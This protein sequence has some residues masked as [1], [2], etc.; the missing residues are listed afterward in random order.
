MIATPHQLGRYEGKN[1]PA[2]IRL[3]VSRL[4]SALVENQIPLRISPG[5]DVRVDHRLDALL[6]ADKICSLAD[7]GRYLLLELPHETYIELR[8][9]SELFTE[10]GRTLIVSHPERNAVLSRRPDAVAP[11]LAAGAVLQITAGSLLGHFGSTAQSSAWKWLEAGQAHLVATDAHHVT[12]RPPN[13]T[14]AIDKI[15]S[16]LGESIAKRV[17]IENPLRVLRG[18]SLLPVERRVARRWLR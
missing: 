16:K 13:L 10:K 4:Q 7:A 5:G 11:W 12:A 14:G 9:L 17:C 15:A 2:D 6:E 18:E 8:Q 1:A 3:A